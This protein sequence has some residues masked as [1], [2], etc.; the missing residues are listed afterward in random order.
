MKVL[1]VLNTGKYSGAENVAITIINSLRD[2]VEGV[3]ASLEG[4]IEEVL[5]EQNIPF[6]SLGKNK[7]EWNRLKLVIKETNPDIIHCHD[8]TT[9][10]LVGSCSHKIPIINHL[11]N[12]PP[13]I[14]KV[15]VNSFIYRLASRKFDRILTVSDSV[16]DEYIFGNALKKKTIIVGNPI[17]REVILT[18]S[19]EEFDGNLGAQ[20]IDVAFLG[21]L[22]PQKNPECFVDII[23]DLNRLNNNKITAVMI[24]DGELRDKIEQLIKARKLEKTINLLGFQKNPYCIL[25][26]C[27]ILCMPSRWEGFGLAAVEAMTLG[28][29]I[30]AAPVGGLKELV[31]DSCGKL[32]KEETEFVSSINKWLKDEEWYGEL[33]DGAKKRSMELENLKEYSK[34]LKNV[35]KCLVK[36]NE[37]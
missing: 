10:V 24:G 35:Y 36:G 14:K 8:Y 7:I 31:N 26:N 22:S 32:C 5:S 37:G 12:N 34:N 16:M 15:C 11:H 21:R 27:K 6:F 13:W 20:M 29:P 9:G 25:K 18:K 17:S 1:H 19:R 4:E 3:Y 33:R 23:E 30:A 28:I 2:K